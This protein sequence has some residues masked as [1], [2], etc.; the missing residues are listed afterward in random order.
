MSITFEDVSGF[1]AQLPDAVSVAQVQEAAAQRLRELDKA[2]YDGVIPG[3]RA[4][5]TDTLSPAVLR[6]LTGTVQER[7]RTGTRAGFLLDEA[8]TDRPR[9]LSHR[10]YRVPQTTTRYRLSSIP[11][12]CLELIEG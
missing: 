1:I 3:R 11:I 9:A 10:R 8:S 12:S 6:G 5:T 2:A 7:N 4:R